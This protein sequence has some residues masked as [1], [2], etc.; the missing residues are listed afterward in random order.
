MKLIQTKQARRHLKRQYGISLADFNENGFRHVKGSNA[1][2]VELTNLAE[3][4][5]FGT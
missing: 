5:M 2:A 1:L 3:N 4:I